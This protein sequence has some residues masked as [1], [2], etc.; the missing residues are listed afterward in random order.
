MLLACYLMHKP[1]PFLC[2]V[3]LFAVCLLFVC[4]LLNY[5]FVSRKQ[6][7]EFR[8]YPRVKTIPPLRVYILR[9]SSI[10]MFFAAIGVYFYIATADVTCIKSINYLGFCF[11]FKGVMSR[12]N[13]TGYYK[14]KHIVPKI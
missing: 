13:L 9:R 11:G 6:I 5:G 3:C 4:L 14:N 8:L 1:T 7:E 2:V 12:N 10:K